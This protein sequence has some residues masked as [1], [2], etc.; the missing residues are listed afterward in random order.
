MN[1]FNV[2]GSLKILFS[3]KCPVRIYQWNFIVTSEAL[4][5]VLK[6]FTTC[7]LQQISFPPSCKV[8]WNGKD[9]CV[10][11]SDLWNLRTV[12]LSPHVEYQILFLLFPFRIP[13]SIP[14]E[15]PQIHFP[16]QVDALYLPQTPKFS[17]VKYELNS[18][19]HA[20]VFCL[21][22]THWKTH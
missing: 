16:A 15:T 6:I 7:S 21:I 19:L 20:F 8:I 11:A 14:T 18:P 22:P 1:R 4:H 13:V 10:S 3:H 2:D 17:A 12:F 9:M 5:H